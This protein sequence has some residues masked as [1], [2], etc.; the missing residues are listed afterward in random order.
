MKLYF[1]PTL[2]IA[3]VVAG[4]VLGSQSAF[5]GVV[6]SV[7]APGVEAS[8]QSNIITETFNTRSQGVFTTLSSTIGNYTAGA[9]SSIILP[10]DQ[11]GGAVD[12]NDHPTQYV[13]V[14]SQ[15]HGPGG[16]MTL[17]LNGPADY[18]GMWWSA[19]DNQNSL[20]IY[21]SSDPGTTYTF[22]S[23]QILP[24]LGGNLAYYGNPQT[25]ANSN[26][27]YVYV[28]FNATPGTS[29]DTI[30]FTNS[31]ATGFESDNHSIRSVPEPS[32]LLMGGAASI[33]GLAAVARRRTRKV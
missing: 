24:L 32:S 4:S 9:N 17:K 31:N 21:N 22:T 11:Y 3:A 6:A 29:F 7:E 8:T 26:E 15:A 5:A 14:G 33:I 16:S 12:E 27:A 30:V 20:T 2:R 28:N 1:A 25:G 19:I 18:F 13:S 10:P 23:A